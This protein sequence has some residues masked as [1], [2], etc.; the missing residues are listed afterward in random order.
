MLNYN[1][2]KGDV[3][4]LINKFKLKKAQSEDRRDEWEKESVEEKEKT[5]K[6]ENKE[7]K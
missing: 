4:Y 5:E 3:M 1:K 2:P 7:Q 6:E